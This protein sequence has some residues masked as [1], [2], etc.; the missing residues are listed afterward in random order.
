MAKSNLPFQGPPC[1]GKEVYQTQLASFH[2]FDAFVTVELFKQGKPVTIKSYMYDQPVPDLP[3][4]EAVIQSWIVHRWTRRIDC[5]KVARVVDG[6]NRGHI[7]AT[8]CL[9]QAMRQADSLNLTHARTAEASV[10][11]GWARMDIC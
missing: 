6:K 1:E 4:C 8:N 11:R 3:D 10:G 9:T 2:E 7:N 5:K